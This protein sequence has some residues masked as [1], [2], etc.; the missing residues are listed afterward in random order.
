MTPLSVLG[1]TYVYFYY[2]SFSLCLFFKFHD[3]FLRSLTWN[4]SHILFNIIFCFYFLTQFD[5]ELKILFRSLVVIAAHSSSKLFNRLWTYLRSHYLEL[6]SPICYF[7]VHQ[8]LER[9][10]QFLPPQEIFLGTFIDR[11]FLSLM[12]Q[13]REASRKVFEWMFFFK[14]L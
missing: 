2:L 5:Y 14:S 6:T 3:L 9:P 12:L 10:A 7:M 1:L 4:G 13:T 8:E 11:G